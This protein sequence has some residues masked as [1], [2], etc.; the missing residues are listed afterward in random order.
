MSGVPVVI[1]SR[2]QADGVLENFDGG[3]SAEEI[4]DLFDLEERSVRGVLE[5]AGRLKN[6]AA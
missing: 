4:A 6:V 2:V 5:F 1:H 3:V